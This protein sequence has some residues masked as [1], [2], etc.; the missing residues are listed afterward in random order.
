MII[1]KKVSRFALLFIAGTLSFSGVLAQ[2]N[3]A[4]IDAQVGIIST[5]NILRSSD[6]GPASDETI[7]LA[8]VNFSFLRQTSRLSA[9]ISGE[10]NRRSYKNGFVDNETLARVYAN[11]AA[12]LV[13]ERLGWTIN[14]DHGQQIINPLQALSPENREDVTILSTGPTLQLPIGTRNRVT[15]RAAVA[16]IQY[17]IRPFDSQGLGGELGIV[18]DLSDERSMSLNVESYSLKYDRSDL[19]APIDTHKAY[20][21]ID[22]RNARGNTNLKIGSNRFESAGN[23]GDGLFLDLG[24][25]RQLSPNSRLF[26]SL[27]SSYETNGDLFRRI[28]DFG[29]QS[30]IVGSPADEG[31][32]SQDLNDVLQSDFASVAYSYSRARTSASA[33]INWQD[34]AYESSNTFDRKVI[35]LRGTIARELTPRLSLSGFVSFSDSDYEVDSRQDE[36][37]AIGVG[38]DYLAGKRLSIQ[39]SID[40]Y[41]R[42]SGTPGA[43]SDELR[44]SVFFRYAIIGNRT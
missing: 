40:H 6:T 31:V 14:A 10:V 2:E 20:F 27:G 44:G 12:V 11:V 13:E 30:G 39:L 28:R 29:R 3:Q 38:I 32:D 41:D 19:S 15:A 17:E 23:E 34:L 8:G 22:S 42:D 25:D 16:D 21:A 35:G 1:M 37:V 24:I 4:T 18:R 7:Y 9:D 33:S 5:D 26:A 36:D 43:S